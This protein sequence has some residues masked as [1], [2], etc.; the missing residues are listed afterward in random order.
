MS[1]IINTL[2]EE[3][4]KMKI[5]ERIHNLITVEQLPIITEQLKAFKTEIDA[6]VQH[7]LSL[8]VTEDNLKIVKSELAEIRKFQSEL[9]TRRK[10]VKNQ[11]L[12]PYTEFEQIYNEI[13]KK[14]LAEAVNT[15]SDQVKSREDK[16]KDEKEQ[17]IIAYFNEYAESLGID[18]VPFRAVGCNVTLS[19]S[20][21]KLKE[22]VKAYLDKTMDD[23]KLIA[24]QEHKSEILVEYKRSLNVSQAITTVSERFK[25]IE[26]E[27]Q[28]E[29]Q[30]QAERQKAEENEAANEAAFEPFTS[31]VP[32]EIETPAEEL[33]QNDL[34]LPQSEQ[35]KVYPLKFTVYGT[36]EQLTEFATHIK[37]YLEE[38][39][40]KYGK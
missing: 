12:A 19:V 3:T 14:P 39:G 5:E 35:E 10:E 22:Q 30:E 6:R 11:V 28:R 38:R 34:P 24:T 17:E 40:M 23:L 16:L 26:E 25:A 27:K 18:F 13:A 21:K 31:N 7:I 37:S 1:E 8:E 36:K 4:P 33:L 15:I 32:Q 29:L 2:G 9:E 20:K